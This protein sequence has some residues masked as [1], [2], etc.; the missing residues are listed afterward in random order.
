MKVSD[1]STIVMN[2]GAPVQTPAQ[3][4][5]E[6]T[7][8][9]GT[10]WQGV[11]VGGIPGIMLG[12]AGTVFAAN[13]P[14]QDEEAAAEEVGEEVVEQVVE[15]DA[16]AAPEEVTSAEGIDTVV[17]E[18]TVPEIGE[19]VEVASN[20]NDNMSFSEAFASARAEVGPGG[21]FVWNGNVYSTYYEE[22][23]DSMTEEQKEEF[24]DAVHNTASSTTEEDSTPEYANN[25]HEASNTDGGV[26]VVSDE[27]VETEDGQVIRVTGVVVDGHYGEVY[28]YDNDGQADAALI[29][30]NDDGRPD[31]AMVDENGDGYISEVEV[32]SMD[33]SGMVSAGNSAHGSTGNYHEASYQDGGVQ[34]VSDEVVETE[35]GQ[36][37]RVTGVV[38]DGHYGEVYDYDNDGQADAALYDANDDGAP[39]LAMVDENGDGYISENE[40]YSVT[41]SGMIAM[42]CPNPE[43]ALYDDMP[44]YTNDADTSSFA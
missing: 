19:T 42:N 17:E 14:V 3:T 43:D 34:V 6:K 16:T 15:E 12:S 20:V 26:Q 38:A 25:Y 22:E 10:F 5:V 37:V 11:L 1:E 28:D 39:D 21:V 7:N 13:A 29:D 36:V 18:A 30:T 8:K 40:V 2:E 9:K 24:S 35:D 4:P 41:D 23:W 27:V 32:Y 44:D 33:E 31:L